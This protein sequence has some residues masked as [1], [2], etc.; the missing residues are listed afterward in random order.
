MKGTQTNFYDKWTIW[1][2]S[3]DPVE[4][5]PDA[6]VGS[7][8]TKALVKLTEVAS[9]GGFAIT[10]SSDSKDWIGPLSAVVPAG[11][12]SL[13]ISVPTPQV[14]SRTQVVVKFSSVYGSYSKGLTLNPIE[15][16]KV[17]LS[18]STAYHTATQGST[19]T[20]TVII[21]CPAPSGGFKVD[22]TS[23][24]KGVVVPASITVPA[25]ATQVSFTINI[26]AG[27]DSFSCGIEARPSQPLVAAVIKVKA[28]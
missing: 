20:G 10:I 24:E 5:S 8:S 14:L 19:S 1:A 21:A 9:A 3:L 11:S 16:T 12:N 27:K 23:T 15:A 22:L 25:G 2:P 7:T 17:T 26:L 6:V 18:P 28:L 13:T 4:F